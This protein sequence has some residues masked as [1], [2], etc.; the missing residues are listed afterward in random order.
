MV[1]VTGVEPAVLPWQEE[2]LNHLAPPLGDGNA[3][4]SD[5]TYLK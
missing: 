2:N 4:V 3:H 1:E 5:Y